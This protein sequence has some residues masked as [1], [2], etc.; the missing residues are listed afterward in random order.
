M[1]M[2]N[3]ETKIENGSEIIFKYTR[4]QCVVYGMIGLTADS[5]CSNIK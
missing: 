4:T 2:L 3:E 1:E 5:A